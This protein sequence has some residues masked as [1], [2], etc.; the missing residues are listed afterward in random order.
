MPIK[1]PTIERCLLVQAAHWFIDGTMPLPDEVYQRAPIVLNAEK[2]KL[3]ELFLALQHE[4]FDV[5]GELFVYFKIS[6]KHPS[7]VQLLN[8]PPPALSLSRNVKI[9]IDTL[10]FGDVNFGNNAI[11]ST[12]GFSDDYAKGQFEKWR[13]KFPRHEGWFATFFLEKVTVNFTNF[14]AY[15]SAANESTQQP[16]RRGAKPKYKWDQIW[17]EL[18]VRADLDNLPSTQAECIDEISQWCINKF[19]KAPS[20]TTLKEKLRLVYGHHRKVGK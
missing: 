1:L 12:R 8:A 19:D 7:F 9:L 3:R 14:R 5:R 18:V 17:A 10:S 20:E 2:P 4:D 6:R 15:L 16:E 13:Q 11:E